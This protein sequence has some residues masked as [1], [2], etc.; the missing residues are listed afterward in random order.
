MKGCV[1]WVCS[2]VTSVNGEVAGEQLGVED[3]PTEDRCR[4]AIS[5]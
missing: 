4:V 3:Q 1:T 5:S 2:R